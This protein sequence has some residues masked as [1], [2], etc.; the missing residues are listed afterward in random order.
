MDKKNKKT[1]GRCP[2][3]ASG[4]SLIFAEHGGLSARRSSIGKAAGQSGDAHTPKEST[5]MQTCAEVNT[6][7]HVYVGREG[8]TRQHEGAASLYAHVP[9]SLAA[10]WAG[11]LSAL[12][13]DL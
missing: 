10:L 13:G 4:L 11:S 3:R 5:N 2:L 6:C 9:I 1:I 7:L 8:D 12:P